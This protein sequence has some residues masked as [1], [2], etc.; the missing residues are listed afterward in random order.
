M[1][2][3]IVFL[4]RQRTP[5]HLSLVGAPV[6]MQERTDIHM[7]VEPT[8]RLS[9][10]SAQELMDMLYA[11]GIRPRQ[12]KDHASTVA[13]LNKHL[14]DMRALTFNKLGVPKP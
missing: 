4:L 12:A 13:A 10:D 11:I 7:N 5:D 2:D 9:Y 14:E 1:G 6:V 3:D 8:F